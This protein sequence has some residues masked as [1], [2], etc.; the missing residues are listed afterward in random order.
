MIFTQHSYII[1]PAASMDLTHQGKKKMAH[2]GPCS[3]V[4][5]SHILR[6]RDSS[7]KADWQLSV[8]NQEHRGQGYRERRLQAE[9][10]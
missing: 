3:L 7:R 5:H 2:T 1:C 8:G 9:G 4:P 6:G 10:Q